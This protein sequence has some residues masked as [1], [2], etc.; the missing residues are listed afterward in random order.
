MAKI[1]SFLSWNVEHFSNSQ[2]RV[3]LVVEAIA[4]KK[5]DVFALYEVKGKAVFAAMQ[6]K[7][8]NY[9]ISITESESVVEILVGVRNS[10][11]S[12]VTQRNELQSKT[13]TLR[14]GALATIT[15]NDEVYSFLFL[16][17]KSFAD[18]RDWGLR[19]DMLQHVC[20]LKRKIERSLDGDKKANFIALGDLNTMGMSAAYNNDLDIDGAK[21]LDYIDNRLTASVNGMR[22]LA[23]SYEATWWNGKSNW[24]PSNLDHVLAADHLKFKK[25][26][27]AE[28]EVSGWVDEAT[29]AARKNWIAKHSDHCMLYGEV[30]S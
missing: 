29:T 23:K 12:F 21:E 15:K 22:R 6:E 9:N 27:T 4:A 19:D 25:F 10:L 5:P 30:R 7:M 20:S 26:G 18:P 13:P 2:S 8:P 3:E 16:H 24:Q 11:S 14:P 28:V 17:L 1:L